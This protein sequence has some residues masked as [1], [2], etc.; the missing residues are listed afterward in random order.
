M[1][2]MQREETTMDASGV[3]M[4]APAAATAAAAS[5]SEYSSS[6][7]AKEFSRTVSKKWLTSMPGVFWIVQGGM[8][9]WGRE[10]GEVGEVGGWGVGGG[11]NWAS[12]GVSE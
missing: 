1:V 11:M 10:V 8:G 9:G 4:P 5:I 3:L 7:S 6:S 12:E 2:L